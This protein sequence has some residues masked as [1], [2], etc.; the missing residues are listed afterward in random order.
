LIDRLLRAAHTVLEG[1][2]PVVKGRVPFFA[3]D[4]GLA[5]RLVR[6]ITWLETLNEPATAL[7]ANSSRGD[8]R[9][10]IAVF[11]GGVVA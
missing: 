9:R 6:V 1:I 3:A 5:E 11:R 7:Y 8:A 2:S 10:L 4:L